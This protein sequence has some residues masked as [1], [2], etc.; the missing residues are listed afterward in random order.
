MENNIRIKTKGTQ[1]CY[2]WMDEHGLHEYY[3][4]KMCNDIKKI[5]NFEKRISEKSIMY[6]WNDEGGY[7]VYHLERNN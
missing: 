6:S 4:E 2:S 3:C 7:H 1:Y 5:L